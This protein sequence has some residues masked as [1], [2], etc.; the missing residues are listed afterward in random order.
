M[1]HTD[2][3]ENPRDGRKFQSIQDAN[4][5]L[6]PLTLKSI[7]GRDWW[8]EIPRDGRKFQSEDC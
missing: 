1:I 8:I 6:E 4:V 5:H 7:W 2:W 3:I